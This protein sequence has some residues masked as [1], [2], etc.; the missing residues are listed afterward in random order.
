MATGFVWDTAVQ[1]EVPLQERPALGEPQRARA[2][3]PPYWGGEIG[4]GAGNRP[5]G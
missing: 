5:L 3:D 2:C 1:A 4:I